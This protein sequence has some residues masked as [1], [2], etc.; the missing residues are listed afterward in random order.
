MF[1]YEKLNEYIIKVK[2]PDLIFDEIKIWKKECDKI[3]N[4]KLSFLKTMDNAGTEGNNYQVSVSKFLIYDGFWLPYVL[5]LISKLCGGRHRDYYLREWPGHFES[6]VWI[7]YAY[8]NNYNPI[9]SHSGFVSGVIYLQNQNDLT[10][11]PDQNFS[12]Q[13][14]PGEM[15]LFPSTLEHQVEKI[16]DNYER[17]TFAFNI[18]LDKNHERVKG[19]HEKK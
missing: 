2:L 5:R 10:I 8:K 17:I 19:H 15:I 7:N 11:F 18:N 1:E 9:H 4:H 6:D 13:G 14:K 12:V 16:K 3:K